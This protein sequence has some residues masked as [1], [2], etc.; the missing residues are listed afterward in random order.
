MTK[1]KTRLSVETDEVD[2]KL[3][4]GTQ[5][6]RVFMVR[7]DLNLPRV[8]VKN[9]LDQIVDEHEAFLLSLALL[10]ANYPTV[11]SVL[12]AIQSDPIL[13]E[14]ERYKHIMDY[15]IFGLTTWGIPKFPRQAFNSLTY[16]VV[17]TSWEGNVLEQHGDQARSLM[18]HNLG[19]IVISHKLVN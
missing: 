4:T 15:A 18:S 1:A 17:S 14:H 6:S 8:I 11:E 16:G 13:A 12:T 10:F 3:E 9:E 2:R 5:A 7:M 19:R